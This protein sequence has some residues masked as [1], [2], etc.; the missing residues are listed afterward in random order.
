VRCSI[1]QRR[2]A[3]DIGLLV[4]RYGIGAVMVIAG[5]VLLV[6]V[7]G[8]G[9]EGF[10]MAVGGGLSV[11][12]LNLLYRMGVSGDEDRARE[13]EAR[14]YFDEHGVWPDDP[15]AAKARRWNLPAGVTPPEEDDAP[16]H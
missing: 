14:R 7:P 13:E 6:A 4:V 10:A 3:S 5:I 2:S 12:L 1:G 16:R 15:P 11:V 8:T 9:V